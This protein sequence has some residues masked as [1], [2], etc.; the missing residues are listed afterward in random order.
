MA[1]GNMIVLRS[2]SK[3]SSIRLEINNYLGFG[4]AGAPSGL[5]PPCKV[6]ADP[7]PKGLYK[8]LANALNGLKIFGSFLLDR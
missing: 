2:G 7:E 4:G 8:M 6:Q 1:N 3:I 5:P